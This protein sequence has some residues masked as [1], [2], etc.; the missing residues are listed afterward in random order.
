M[1][2]GELCQVVLAQVGAV[3]LLPSEVAAGGAVWLS[4][5]LLRCL[6]PSMGQARQ[7]NTG[8]QLRAG[9]QTAECSAGAETQ[10]CSQRCCRGGNFPHRVGCIPVGRNLFC[11]LALNCQICLQIA[12]PSQFPR[13]CCLLSLLAG[14]TRRFG[15]PSRG[16]GCCKH[17][18]MACHFHADLTQRPLG[19]KAPRDLG[20]L[21]PG[22]SLTLETSQA[23]F[24]HVGWCSSLWSHR[25]CTQL[26]STFSP[27]CKKIL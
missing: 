9:C 22:Q 11:S 4:C 2:A 20:N 21:A 13:C 17:C 26:L 1:P 12:V 5:H 6:P 19:W 24:W 3:C 15:C 7:G 27:P 25:P 10:P 14:T 16:K 18:G 8:F 23:Q